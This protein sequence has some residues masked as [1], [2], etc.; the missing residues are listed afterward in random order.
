[1]N[2]VTYITFDHNTQL[3][4]RMAV[5]S[6]KQLRGIT[7]IEK[8]RASY[9]YYNPILSCLKIKIYN[10]FWE[11]SVHDTSIQ[12]AYIKVELWFLYVEVADRLHNAR[13]CA[14]AHAHARFKP[15]FFFSCILWCIY[16][17]K[18]KLFIYFLGFSFTTQF[19]FI[20]LY[21]TGGRYKLF[22]IGTCWVSSSRKHHASRVQRITSFYSSIAGKKLT[23][24]AEKHPL[25]HDTHNVLKSLL[26]LINCLSKAMSSKFNIKNH[27][28]HEN[29]IN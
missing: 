8:L 10:P 4:G 28:C 26:L 25:S 7:P 13:A 6:M 16:K 9:N 21:L 5:L 29:D 17:N 2:N 22:G 12:D 15:S 3:L 23:F 1:M 11:L 24:I 18:N 14:R 27:V 19:L 20:Y